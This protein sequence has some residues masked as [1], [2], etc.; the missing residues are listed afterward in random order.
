VVITANDAAWPEPDAL[1][2]LLLQ[3]LLVE[4]PHF[5]A[6]FIGLASSR[7]GLPVGEDAYRGPVSNPRWAPTA[8]V[9]GGTHDGEATYQES[10]A[11]TR[12]LDNARL[13]TREGDGH[14]SYF[15]S[16]CVADYVNAYLIDGTLPPE[17][18]VCPTP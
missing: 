11:M 3:R 5:A 8:L 6:P 9:I 4:A 16:R 7:R 10:Q 15:E 17:G 13:L 14:G 1:Y 18:A 12:Q 2:R